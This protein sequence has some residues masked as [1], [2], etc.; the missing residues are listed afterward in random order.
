MDIH[1]ACRTHQAA[2]SYMRMQDFSDVRLPPVSVLDE[3][4]IRTPHYDLTIASLCSIIGESPECCSCSGLREVSYSFRYS[5]FN[6][7]YVRVTCL[8]SPDVGNRLPIHFPLLGLP[9]Q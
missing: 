6:K 5:A 9:G 8:I 7:L 3:L 1:Y 4:L 2:D